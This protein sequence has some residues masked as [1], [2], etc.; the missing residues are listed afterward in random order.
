MAGAGL[1]GRCL[2][3]AV[4]VGAARPEGGVSACHCAICRRWSGA[5]MFGIEVSAAEVEVTGEVARYRSSAFAERAFCPACGTHLWFRSD[6]SDEY[7][8]MPG[9]FDGAAG[10]PLARENYA[11]RALAAV[12]LA[13]DHERVTAAAREAAHRHV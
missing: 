4:R 13:G 5:A 9:L 2:C 11:D 12:R 10:M 1:Q 3:G 6:G 8:F 7:E